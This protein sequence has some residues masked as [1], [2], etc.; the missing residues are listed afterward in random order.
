MVVINTFSLPCAQPA[1]RTGS[2][3]ID[4]TPRHHGNRRVLKDK[5]LVECSVRVRNQSRVGP[6]N[7]FILYQP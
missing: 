4:V 3:A 1:G 7:I 5:G 2:D 6:I